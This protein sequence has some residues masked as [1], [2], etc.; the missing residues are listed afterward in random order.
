MLSERETLDNTRINDNR[1]EIVTAAGPSPPVQLGCAGGAMV[2]CFGLTGLHFI[3]LSDV[4][5]TGS[6]SAVRM[7]RIAFTLDS[8][9][10]EAISWVTTTGGIGG[11][12][13]RDLMIESIER[14]YGLVD[15]V[16]QPVDLF[17]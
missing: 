4:A 6:R 16:P 14:R 15:R 12:D 17:G 9:D 1:R 10:R 11:G 13:I 2:G 3:V 8:C 5:R 7:V